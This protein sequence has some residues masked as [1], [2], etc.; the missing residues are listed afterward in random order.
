MFFSSENDLKEGSVKNKN[1][2]CSHLIPAPIEMYR[3]LY[4]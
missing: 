3:G 2:E 1:R 4:R